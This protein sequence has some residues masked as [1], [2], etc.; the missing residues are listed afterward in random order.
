MKGVSVPTHVTDWNDAA[1]KAS[2]PNGEQK[3]ALLRT[4]PMDA[5]LWNPAKGAEPLWNPTI[6][7]CF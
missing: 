6:L 4:P 2:A 3:R 7:G 5:V 1:D